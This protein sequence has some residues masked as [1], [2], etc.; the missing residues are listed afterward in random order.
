MVTSSIKSTS[1]IQHFS[2]AYPMLFLMAFS[3]LILLGLSVYKLTNQI[4]SRL[5]ASFKSSTVSQNQPEEILFQFDESLSLNFSCFRKEVCIGQ[6]GFGTVNLCS[7]P[8]NPNRKFA[9][10]HLTPL[11]KAEVSIFFLQSQVF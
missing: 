8:S 7:L 6:G 3:F 4:R 9:V 5:Q 10:K 11:E 1:T 2:K